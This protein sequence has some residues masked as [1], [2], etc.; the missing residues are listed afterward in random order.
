MLPCKFNFRPS[1]FV[2][3]LVLFR[4]SCRFESTIY[5][6]ISTLF[7]ILTSIVLLPL[8]RRRK[9]LV[10]FKANHGKFKINNRYVLYYI[11]P[12]EK[13]QPTPKIPHLKHEDGTLSCHVWSCQ[14]RSGQVR[15]GTHKTLSPRLVR[16]QLSINSYTH[17]STAV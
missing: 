5:T 16:H 3:S 10:P 6:I 7:I 13:P 12:Q 17:N 9:K 8:P 2:G 15:S 4:W 11:I 14:V 1:S